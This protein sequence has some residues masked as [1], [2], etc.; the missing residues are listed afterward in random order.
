[1]SGFTSNIDAIERVFGPLED[2]RLLDIG[3]GGGRL[4][5][6][7][8]RRGAVPTGVDPSEEMVARA[9]ALA[10]DATVRQSGGEVLP[11]EDGE[12]EG[13]IILNVLHHVPTA[14][15]QRALAEG[16]RVVKPGAALLVI[17]PLA[18]G[19]YQEI[20]SPIDDET[21]IRATALK[22]LAAFVA[23]GGATQE[24]QVEYTIWVKEESVEAVLDYGRAVDPTRAERIADVEQEVRER[25]AEHARPSKDGFKIEQ[26]MIATALRHNS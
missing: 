9:S 5:R 15:M 1:M 12:F 26:P 11:F 22:E 6:A 21:E 3:C 10:P 20:F 24:F 17:E 25:F 16:L 18:R 14:S 13:A 4:L 7:L 19:G 8:S 2:R 23:G